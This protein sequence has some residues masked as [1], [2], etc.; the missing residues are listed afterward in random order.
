MSDHASAIREAALSLK[1]G[2][3]VRLIHHLSDPGCTPGDGVGPG[4]GTTVGLTWPSEQG[5]E[6]DCLRSAASKI[7]CGCGTARALS[8]KRVLSSDIMSCIQSEEEHDRDRPSCRKASRLQ[9]GRRK[10]T[11]SSSIVSAIVQSKGSLVVTSD[12]HA[13]AFMCRLRGLGY[14]FWPVV[15]RGFS[16]CGLHNRKETCCLHEGPQFDS[17]KHPIVCELPGRC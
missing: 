7:S 4:R 16:M 9:A 2:R 10:H 6:Y 8:A 11:S 1:M 17:L 5:F 13:G 12:L 15:G 3:G 14:N